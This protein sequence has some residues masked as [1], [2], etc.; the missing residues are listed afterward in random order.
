MTAAS[1]A[2]LDMYTTSCASANNAEAKS[3]CKFASENIK[4]DARS[5][6]SIFVNIRVHVFRRLLVF[7]F[8]LPNGLI[9]RKI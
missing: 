1:Y 7:L 2:K 4:M 6:A 9:C 3:M 5:V 8:S